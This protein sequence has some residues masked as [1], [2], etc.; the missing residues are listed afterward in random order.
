MPYDL[1]KMLVVGVASSALFDL[2]EVDLVFREH[3][4]DEYRKYQ[5]EH[6]A[7]PL[8]PGAAFPFIKRLLSLNNLS[9]DGAPLVEVI[10]LSRN[11]PETGLRIMRSTA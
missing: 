8:E 11:D 6:V 5:E 4:E 10:V 9:Q 2:A 3:G 1:E 7:D